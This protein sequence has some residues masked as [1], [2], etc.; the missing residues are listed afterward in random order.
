MVNIEDLQITDEDIRKERIQVNQYFKKESFLLK[1][2]HNKKYEYDIEEFKNVF[3][4][5]YKKTNKRKYKEF[6]LVK[7][8]FTF[9][10]EY[11]ITEEKLKLVN[12]LIEKEKKELKNEK[13]F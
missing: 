9:K 3:V 13:K 6:V 1:N 7:N 11:K 10:R 12:D 8:F 5:Q 4:I 2:L